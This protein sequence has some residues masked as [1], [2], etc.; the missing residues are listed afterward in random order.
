MW[1]PWYRLSTMYSIFLRT[2]LI[3]LLPLMP[4]YCSFTRIP[5]VE[6][7]T[8]RIDRAVAHLLFHR[9]ELSG[10]HSQTPESPSLT[11]L[12]CE[13]NTGGLLSSPR[14]FLSDN[15]R[16]EQ[17]PH[18]IVENAANEALDA[19]N[20]EIGAPNQWWKSSSRVIPSF[21]SFIRLHFHFTC[22]Y[23]DSLV[24]RFLSLSAD[25]FFI[26]HRSPWLRNPS[27]KE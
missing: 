7:E 15:S 21:I 10:K 23:T 25:W 12:P 20:K 19:G 26:K 11:K 27:P 5:D 13:I 18:F 24:T 16:R 3:S 9:P 1:R 14:E 6:T 22:D 8:N 17:K 2:S 4:S